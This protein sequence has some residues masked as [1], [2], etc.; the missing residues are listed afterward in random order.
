MMKVSKVLM[1]AAMTNFLSLQ[2][3][4]SMPVENV[5]VRINDLSGQTSKPLLDKMTAGMQ[6][7][8]DQLLLDK[9]TENISLYQQEYSKLFAD[10]G[11]RALTGYE[12]RQSSISVGA[13]TELTLNVMPWNSTIRNVEV[14]LQFSGLDAQAAAYME[15]RIPKLKQ[16]LHDTIQ[17]ASVDAADWAGGI[18]RKIVRQ[19]IA[20]S[21]PEFKAAVDIVESDDKTVVQVIIYPV[22]QLVSNIKYEMHSES[23]PNILL[24]RLKVKYQKECEKLRG[25]PVSYLENNKKEYEQYLMR[26][27]LE[28]DEVRQY[29]LKPQV[30]ISTG[31]D[32]QVDIVIYSEDYKIWFEGYA[33]LGRDKDNI[34]GRAHF[35]KYIS[36][37]DEIFT[38]AGLILDD[39]HWNM[40]LGY[41]RYWGKSS[42]SYQRIMPDGENNYRLEYD[43]SNKWRLRAEHYSGTDRNEY[44]ARY[45]IHEFLS[46][47]YVYGEDEFYLRLIG[48]L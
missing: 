29:D 45:R 46:A 32:T 33:D 1:I 13:D 6:V 30:N 15:K 41:T 43:L 27:L 36:P 12:V 28:E 48:N 5:T 35:G 10:I 21:L 20:A 44:G 31:P 14:D 9:D 34:S 25:L 22:G 7:V 11:D 18:L 4:F 19:E 24:N 39:V 16:Q 40:G 47:E 37:R 2:Q 17:G 23:I 8:A 38:E 26:R 42:W 3:A